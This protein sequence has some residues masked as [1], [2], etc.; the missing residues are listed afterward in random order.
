MPPPTAIAELTRTELLWTLP[1]GADATNVFHH[2]PSSPPD[3]GDLTVLAGEWKKFWNGGS[4]YTTNGFKQTFPQNLTLQ[5]IRCTGIGQDPA[6]QWEETVNT[7]NTSG[8]PVPAESA[9]V[10]KWMSGSAG[11]SHRGRTFWPPV[12]LSALEN[13]TG[14]LS[15]GSQTIMGQDILT[16]LTRL[17]TVISPTFEMVVWSRLLDTTDHVDSYDVRRT[18]HHQSRRNTAGA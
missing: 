15:T 16:L 5:T 14:L 18:L 2:L 1:N 8:F 10:T 17:Y 9:V 13:G 11:R 4:P 6:P 7:H 3:T 12:Q